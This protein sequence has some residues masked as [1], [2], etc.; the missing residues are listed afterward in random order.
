[1]WALIAGAGLILGAAAPAEASSTAL[2]NIKWPRRPQAGPLPADARSTVGW[3]F[4]TRLPIEVTHLGFYDLSGDGLAVS[5]TVGI[6]DDQQNLLASAVVE[7]DSAR[8]GRFRYAVLASPILLPGGQHFVIGGT[9]GQGADVYPYG[10][11]NWDVLNTH[12]R[13][14]IQQ[15]SMEGIFPDDDVLIPPLTFPAIDHDS[16]EALAVNFRFTPVAVAAG[17]SLPEPGVIGMVAVGAS[18]LLRRRR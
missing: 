10:G 18:V 9:V 11:V 16:G 3:S 17:P 5:H 4:R 6:W 1:L 8:R 7:S 15:R 14:R 2:R 13:V 12:D